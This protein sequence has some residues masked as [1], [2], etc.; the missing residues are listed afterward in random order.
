MEPRIYR[1]ERMPRYFFAEFYIM[2]GICMFLAGVLLHASILQQMLPLT[3]AVTL[4]LTFLG[5]STLVILLGPRGVV[6]SAPGK[7]TVRP[8][9]G[10]EKEYYALRDPVQFQPWVDERGSILLL[11]KD[12][13]QISIGAQILPEDVELPW[14]M[15]R[16]EMDALQTPAYQLSPEDFQE[17]VSA[18]AAT[19][20]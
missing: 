17:L 5:G 18:L 1:I 6:E 7:V 4:P 12:D 14:R 2:L 13:G 16:G 3:V 10:G 15:K 9:Y 11:G 8:I 19:R 20:R